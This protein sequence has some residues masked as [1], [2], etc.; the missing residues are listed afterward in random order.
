M[1]ADKPSAEVSF[2]GFHDIGFNAPGIR[3]AGVGS[4]GLRKER[5]GSRNRLGRCAYDD[6]FRVTNRIRKA[7]C[8]PAAWERGFDRIKRFLTTGPQKNVR[9]GR[10]AKDRLRDGTPDETRA[11]NRDRTAQGTRKILPE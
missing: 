1:R 4:E 10:M 9:I 7:R 8:N 3:D 11:E 6:D 5:S 2:E